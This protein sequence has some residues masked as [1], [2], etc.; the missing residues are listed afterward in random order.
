[1]ENSYQDNDTVNI[2]RE[3]CEQILR[4]FVCNLDLYETEKDINIIIKLM[5]DIHSV[6]GSSAIA[7][8]PEVQNIAHK[9]EDI[10]SHIKEITENPDNKNDELNEQNCLLEIRQLL[11]LIAEELKND[12]DR[13]DIHKQVFYDEVIKMISLLKSDITVAE[14]LAKAANNLAENLNKPETAD[15]AR[16]LFNILSK[17]KN[18][19]DINSNFLNTLAGA[20]RIIKKI[21]VDDNEAAKEELFFVKQRLSV[22]EQMLSAP[23]L[24]RTVTT[25]P[26]LQKDDVIPN[27]FKM[28]GKESIKTL[29][30]ETTKL[31]KLYENVWHL[32]NI[33]TKTKQ[34]YKTFIDLTENFSSKIFDIEKTI[35][36]MKNDIS[37]YDFT[38]I[39]EHIKDTVYNEIQ[40]LEDNIQSIQVEFAEFEKIKAN[41]K[42]SG[43][44]FDD[45]LGMVMSTVKNI[46]IL[47]IGVILHM[48]PR[49][50]RDIAD[51][52]NK[53]V[54]IEIKGSETGVDKKI[55]ED[56]KMPLIHLLR[57]AVDH[58]IEP[59]E[60]R[61]KKGKTPFGKITISAENRD[62]KFIISVQD[63]GCGINFDKIK[64]KAL[65]DKLLANNEIKNLKRTDFLKMLF[66]PG[67]STEDKVTELS[68]RGM[69]LDIVYT[70]ISALNGQIK[71]DT[72]QGI[73]TKITMIIPSGY[74]S[75]NI[76]FANKNITEPKAKI[77]LVDDSK[78]T[79][80]HFSRI[81]KKA[82]YYVCK[83]NNAKDALNELNIASYDM[84][85]SDVEMPDMNGLD[86]IRKVRNQKDTKDIP[87]IIISM[88]SKNELGSM[89]ENLNVQHLINKADFQENEFLNYVSEILEPKEE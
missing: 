5:R 57:N 24:R 14:E 9:I 35:V 81:L 72:E 61:V 25:R 16:I 80:L 85:I 44:E 21:V 46:R 31:D 63:D 37:E 3:E 4:D 86:F 29:R 12:K 77:L 55:L 48:F 2:Y 53:N 70:T 45:C 51:V 87:V 73:G 75:E 19:K 10:L 71:V 6:K 50:V 40:M 28:L 26:E 56:I 76:S 20:F 30:I 1:M 89:F 52:V 83:Q 39:P 62:E 69:G 32:E 49:M 59:P 27:I 88:L 65:K 43:D 13:T 74:F 66:N 33:S 34:N 8:F 18:E 60:E 23:A 38:D 79:L 22:V 54:M 11:F 84:I 67:F 36:K 64:E 47:P 41:S 78:T 68:G 42:V 82:G 58:G 7:G 17:L 15:I